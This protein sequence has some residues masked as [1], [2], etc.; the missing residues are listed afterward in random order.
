MGGTQLQINLSRIFD[1]RIPASLAENYL[2]IFEW[3]YDKN[4]NSLT[5]LL[6]FAFS[7]PPQPRESTELIEIFRRYETY[8][9]LNLVIVLIDLIDSTIDDTTCWVDTYYWLSQKTFND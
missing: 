8:A 2:N 5:F 1:S 4:E 6:I 7:P 3:I 9:N